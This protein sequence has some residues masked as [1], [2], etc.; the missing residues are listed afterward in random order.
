MATPARLN[1]SVVR[2]DLLHLRFRVGTT[3]SQGNFGTP[4]DNTNWTGRWHWRESKD[5]AEAAYE[6][7][8]TYF[9]FG[10]ADGY[11]DI[12]VPITETEAF[13]FVQLFHDIEFTDTTVNPDWRK[14]WAEGVVTL[15]L[16][17]SRD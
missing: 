8:D 2:G 1:L 11:V 16:D 4:Y 3:D 14:T 17:V 15:V 13:D 5:A 6:F 12:R 10:G 7:D 9:T